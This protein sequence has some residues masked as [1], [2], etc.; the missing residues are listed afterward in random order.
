[1]IIDVKS[2]RE[3]SKLN[4][5]S[6]KVQACNSYGQSFMVNVLGSGHE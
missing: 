1:M 4:N 3:W 6:L 5:L 2:N